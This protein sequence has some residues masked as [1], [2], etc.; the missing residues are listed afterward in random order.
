MDNGAERWR[1]YLSGDDNALRDIINEYGMPLRMFLRSVISDP[2]IA[3]EAT[4][5][6]FVKIAL[7]KPKYNGKAS[8]KTWLFT[9]GRNTAVDMARSRK[10]REAVSLNDT[11]Q[12][13]DSAED[14]YFRSEQNLAL[15]RA[16]EKLMPEYRAVL[17]LRYFENLQVKE[18]AK[19]IKK[20]ENNTK[21]LLH[22]AREALRSQLEKDGFDYEIQ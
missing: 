3:E 14:L 10:T 9:I 22:R 20:S 8:F 5:E 11:V 16:M 13:G 19:I 12:P 1:S 15:H 2:D 21:V 17:F 7:K 4:V 18:T 6:T